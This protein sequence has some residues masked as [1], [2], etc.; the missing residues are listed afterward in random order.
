MLT[1]IAETFASE[2][3]IQCALTNA[4]D[5]RSVLPSGRTIGD[6]LEL[7][8]REQAPATR[9]SSQNRA[10]VYRLTRTSTAINT[11]IP[12]E[13]IDGDNSTVN[14]HPRISKYDFACSLEDLRRVDCS[15]ALP[16]Y[17]MFGRMTQHHPQ[18]GFLSDRWR[19]V[20]L[21]VVVSPRATV[22]GA[23]WRASDEFSALSIC[24]DDLP[25]TFY[26]KILG[27][28]NVEVLN[29]VS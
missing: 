20:R 12:Y 1:T 15:W 14:V 2:A 10:P 24:K 3:N 23:L 6:V 13:I 21:R 26:G 8:E 22:Q 18:L 27:F 9:P 7:L 19:E 5:Q 4:I 17:Q 16:L 29:I 11:C 28:L 25:H